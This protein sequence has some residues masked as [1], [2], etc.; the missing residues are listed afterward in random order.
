MENGER[1]FSID[2]FSLWPLHQGM[3]TLVSLDLLQQTGNWV[4][5][6]PS[7]P[8][9]GI[10]SDKTMIQKDTCSPKFI[11][12]LFTMTK[13][14]KQPKYPTTDEWIKKMWFYIYIYT[15]VCVY[16]CVCVY[17]YAHTHNRIL[18][19]H[20]KEWNNAMDGPRDYH[21]KWSK[22]DRERQ[23]LYDITYMWNLKYDTNELVYETDSQ[24]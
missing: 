24:T 20:K 9:L 22:S 14:W 11:A 5:S 8:F 17:L 15:Y 7:I 6:T 19:S 4:R 23:I 10:Y 13:T 2:W 16:I 1:W 21:T 3:L 12:V 18:L